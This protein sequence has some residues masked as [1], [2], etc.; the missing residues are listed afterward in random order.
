MSK[1][2]WLFEF[3]FLIWI[4][5]EK[6]NILTLVKTVQKSLFKINSVLGPNSVSSKEVGDLK[7]MN[8]KKN[9]YRRQYGGEESSYQVNLA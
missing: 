4:C 5:Y 3:I 8:S 2:S 7:L 9:K 6:R 1:E